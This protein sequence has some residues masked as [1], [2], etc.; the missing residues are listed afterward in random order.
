MSQYLAVR[1]SNTPFLT[2][3]EEDQLVATMVAGRA[4]GATSQVLAAASRARE[5]LILSYA[6]SARARAASA[7]S[8]RHPEAEAAQQEAVL[9]LTIAIDNFDPSRGV[10]IWSYARVVLTGRDARRGSGVS[11]RPV[12]VSFDTPTGRDTDLTLADVLPSDR[13][14]EAA[15]HDSLCAAAVASALA[16]LPQR[17]RAV[18]ATQFGIAGYEPLSVAALARRLGVHERSIG[19]IRA[20][21]LRRLAAAPELLALIA[22]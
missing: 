10:S 20:R 8:R 4:Q 7:Y 3:D 14:T 12:Q 11:L 22:T 5:K 19:K 9:R 15:V 1:L 6:R 17:E 16:L 13:D 18:L 21:A 2:R